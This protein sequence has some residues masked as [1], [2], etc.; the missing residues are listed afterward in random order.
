MEFGDGEAGRAMALED[1]AEDSDAASI[2]MSCASDLS[3]PS[4]KRRA[5]DQG[6][7]LGLIQR[8]LSL[9]RRKK[10]KAARAGTIDR[11][12]YRQRGLDLLQALHGSSAVDTHDRLTVLRS[13]TAKLEELFKDLATA[14]D[15]DP[16]VKALGEAVL[17][18]H[19]LLAESQPTETDILDVWTRIENALQTWLALTPEGG[20]RREGF[21]K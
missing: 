4:R 12:L 18:L 9:F 7:G 1:E 21:W 17:R 14:G 8:L 19:T 3:P 6:L 2:D 20:P 13:L 5:K 15:R 11:S 10:S 16:S